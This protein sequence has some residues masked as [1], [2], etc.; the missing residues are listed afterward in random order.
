MYDWGKPEEYKKWMIEDI[1]DIIEDLK[2]NVDP[3]VYSSANELME[4]ANKEFQYAQYDYESAI[5]RE[6][7][8]EIL[9]RI[10]KDWEGG[11]NW[12][13]KV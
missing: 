5:R 1:S 10:A 7:R 13:N 6:T 2:E 4:Y 8:A 11:W 9:Q 12:I 3:S